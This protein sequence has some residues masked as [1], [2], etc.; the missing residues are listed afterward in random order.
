VRQYR[1]LMRLVLLGAASLIMAALPL[2][3]VSRG[4]H[5]YTLAVATPMGLTT[6]SLLHIVAALETREPEG[7]VP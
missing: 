5:E 7:S 6:L 2:G 3:V 1:D 4:E